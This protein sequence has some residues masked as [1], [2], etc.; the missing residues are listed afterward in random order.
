MDDAVKAALA[1]RAKREKA[2]RSESQT[3][4]VSVSGLTPEQLA[5]RDAEIMAAGNVPMPLAAGLGRGGTFGF[6]D[7]LAAR[8][9]SLLTGKTYDTA[10]EETRAAEAAARESAP[11]AFL[12][13]EI[14]GGVTTAAKSAPLALGKSL[15]GTVGRGAALGATEGAIYGTGTGEGVAGRAKNALQTGILGAG[16]GAAIPA[17]TS[18]IKGLYRAAAN[19][20]ASAFNLGNAGR[21][22]RAI[23]STV[24]ASGKS[25]DD[26]TAEVAAAAADGQPQFRVVD[27]L[28]RSGQRRA[29]GIVRAGG[30]AAD[31]LGDQLAARQ[32]SQGE[33]V[34]E[35]IEDAFDLRG[36]TA[37]KAKETVVKNRR[38][39]AD[40]LYDQAAKDAKPVDVRSAVQ[41][42]D[43]TID[44]ITNSGIKPPRVV[45]EFQKLRAQL[46][47]K[48]PKGEPT[49]L[50]DYKSVLTIW[51]E[52]RAKIDDAY[53]SGKGD[54]GEALKPIRDSL[55][56]SLEDSSDL[57]RSATD[58]YR[59][60]SGVVD[61]F[62]EGAQMASRGRASDNVATFSGLTG[63]E[64]RAARMG[65][66][67]GL[68]AQLERN[69]SPTANKAKPLTSPK[70][71]SEA[72]AIANDPDLLA[73]RVDRE[74]IMWGTQNRALGGSRTADNLADME[75]AERLA[76]GTGGVL[77]SA[78]NFQLG[79][80]VAN[81]AAVIA[82]RLTGQN[83]GTRK[84]IAKALMSSDAGILAKALGRQA[85]EEARTRF[86]D[87][88]LRNAGRIGYESA[89]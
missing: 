85:S 8:T 20:V 48:T 11:G 7:E 40:R 49:T 64:Q 16:L 5:A 39:V 13:G 78:A 19:P 15:L 82:P 21:A 67:D 46:A 51:R 56:S 75:G 80:A 79:D 42:L 1:E 47:G 45:K 30:D 34:G 89:N 4:W 44:N 36:T 86:V 9:E 62:D 2:K 10:L 37:N 73:R 66:G 52:V 27:A 3:G 14:V 74:G 18:G 32:A 33:R 23:S 12:T 61:A 71:A 43:D 58:L 65:Y 60:G 35:Y 81:A 72:A 77:R 76:A 25:L 59:V 53:K 41:M 22:D 87:G 84:L 24:R 54:V 28:G 83:E 63:Q 57:Y 29:S 6:S 17:A 31:E 70:R 88:I 50:S 69:A 38:A 26:V 55:Q 68:L